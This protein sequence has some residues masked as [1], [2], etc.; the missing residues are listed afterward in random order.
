MHKAIKSTLHE[1]TIAEL[2]RDA[3]TWTKLSMAKRICFVQ[4]DAHGKAAEI[5]CE[6]RSFEDLSFYVSGCCDE[7]LMAA[8]KKLI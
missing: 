2:E 1:D 5:V 4:C 8:E 6:G 3:L 7:L